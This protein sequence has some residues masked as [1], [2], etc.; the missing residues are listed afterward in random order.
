MGSNR[1]WYDD[2][3][4]VASSF[5]SPPLACL[6]EEEDLVGEAAEA[7]RMAR[8]QAQQQLLLQGV[9]PSKKERLAFHQW[10]IAFEM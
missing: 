2:V 9:K 7:P 10:E 4:A 3:P 6:G 1:E 5:S 8:L